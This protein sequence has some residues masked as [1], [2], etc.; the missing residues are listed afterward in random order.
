[1]VYGGEVKIRKEYEKWVVFGDEFSDLEVCKGGFFG[2]EH[3]R[4]P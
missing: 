1:M 4:P 2:T 3:R